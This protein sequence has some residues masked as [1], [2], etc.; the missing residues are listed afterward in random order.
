VHGMGQYAVARSIRKKISRD[1]KATIQRGAC[2]GDA[3]KFASAIECL[4]DRAGLAEQLPCCSD[5]AGAL[6]QC[7]PRDHRLG[8][9]GRTKG[10]PHCAPPIKS[11][12]V[13][14]ASTEASRSFA[15][16]PLASDAGVT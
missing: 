13:S 14:A 5:I 1:R 7:R 4:E 15:S 2:R 9:P 10:G 11:S 3:G 16:D 8:E 6:A 12:G